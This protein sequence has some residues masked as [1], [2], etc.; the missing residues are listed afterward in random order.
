MSFQAWAYVFV[1]ATFVLYIGIAIRTRVH[2]TAGFYVARRSVPALA[3]GMATGADWM[4]AA[5]FISMAGLISFLG[6]DGSIYLLGWTGGFVLLALLV[7]PYLRRCEHYT[8]PEFIGERYASQAAR[9]IAILCAVF[10]CFTHI[11]GQMRGVGIV[12]SRFF[13]VEIATGVII[14]GGVV[15]IYAALGG[16]RGITY[17][18]VAQYLILISAYLIPAVAISIKLTGQPIPQIGF[19]STLIEGR[20][21]GLYLLETLDQIH[22]DLGLPEYTGA[23]VAGKKAM[24]DVLAITTVLMIGTA[25]MPHVLVRFFTVRHGNAARWSVMWALLFVAL[26]YTTAPSLAAFTRVNLI[27]TLHNT[28][29]NEAPAWFKN[30]E[31]TGLIRYEDKNGDGLIQYNEGQEEIRELHIDRDIMVLATP[32]IAELPVWVVALVVAGALAAALS[33]AA[34]LLLVISSAISHDLIKSM[35]V[36]EMNE[37]SELCVARIAAGFA[38]VIGIYFGINPLDYV[39]ATI[40]LAFG[41]AASSFFP[42][43]V[44]GIFTRHTTRSGIIAGLLTGLGFTTA[45]ILYFKLLKIGSPDQWWFGISPEGIGVIGAG[46]NFAVAL[47]VSRLTALPPARAL[48]IVD[49]LHTP[50]RI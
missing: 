48:A 5:S 18:Q 22:R 12:F 33:S 29:Y 46:L 40:A 4:S 30:W 24:I 11:M 9:S 19:G 6:Y 23:F 7:A 49:R 47:S 38:I 2:S 50:D 17:T 35:F 26:L 1:A 20:N 34:C 36:R 3:N 21:A 28:P 45:Y 10:I 31:D 27:D 37:Q 25:G 8:V 43:L 42:A 41:L 16:M 39:A 44:L 14:G 13:E 15:F 32:E